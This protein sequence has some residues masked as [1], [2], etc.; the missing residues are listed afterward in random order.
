MINP[1][2]RKG[3]VESMAKRFKLS[4]KVLVGR[5]SD[6]IKK[7]KLSKM[8]RLVIVDKFGR[9]VFDKEFATAETIACILRFHKDG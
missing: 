3:K 1:V 9:V 8:P 5:D 6:I 4:H 7:Y 2:D